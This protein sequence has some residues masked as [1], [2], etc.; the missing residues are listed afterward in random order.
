MMSPNNKV[1][2]IDDTP[3]FQAPG[4][5]NQPDFQG[6][7]DALRS[8]MESL[9]SQTQSAQVNLSDV[10]LNMKRPIDR[11]RGIFTVVSAAPSTPPQ[12]AFDQIQVYVNGATLRLYWYDWSATTWHYVT[13][14]A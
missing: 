5:G 11:A 3:A 2:K 8:D 13:A 14:T 7:I 10:F 4:V 6:Q 9:K 1:G 12:D